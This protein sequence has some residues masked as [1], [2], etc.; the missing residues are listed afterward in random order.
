MTDRPPRLV[1]VIG[2]GGMLGAAIVTRLAHGESFQ[3]SRIPWADSRFAL[4]ALT[5]QLAEFAEA[6]GPQQSWAIVWAAGAG[7]IATPP[8]ML[9]AEA[10]L[11]A[12]FAAEVRG[13]A[14]HDDGVFFLASSAAV[15]AGAAAPPFDENTPP[16]ALSA[17]GH[18]KLA[19]EDA[20]MAALD[21]R[22]ASVVGRIST[23]YGPG[24]RLTKAQ[25]LISLMVLQATLNRPIGI[26]VPMDTLRDYLYVD[27]A[28]VLVLAALDDARGGS[29]HRLRVLASQR[30]T[31]IAE[32][33]KVVQGVAG[34]R[35]GVNQRVTGVA[36]GHIRDL[37][38]RS[39]YPQPA[40]F[41]PLPL[42][43]GVARVVEAVR[44][45]HRTGSLAGLP[46]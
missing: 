26:Y 40:G 34:S 8:D 9:E 30:A 28:A 36:S 15:Y 41:S 6:V 7:V 32:L 27:D 18:A 29:G 21:G 43:V 19:Q 33:V 39:M 11:F 38:L 23:L 16:L 45:A 20:L 31:S 14:L 24:Q 42:P 35:V 37:R 44:A 12:A 4:A 5:Q 17:Y 10:E 22:G 3:G 13:S 25:G 1:W 2:S 46:R